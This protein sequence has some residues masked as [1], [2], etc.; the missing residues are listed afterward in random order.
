MPSIFQ[1]PQG[2]HYR[3]P[4]RLHRLPPELAGHEPP[5]NAEGVK[6]M[7]R[8]IRRTIGA[9]RQGKTPATAVALTACWHCA[10]TH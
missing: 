7:L 9:A 5:T 10:P 3:P 1:R 4:G 6:A 8:G 2:L